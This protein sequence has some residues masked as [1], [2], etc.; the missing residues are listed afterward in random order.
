VTLSD[1]WEAVKAQTIQDVS[2]TRRAIRDAFHHLVISEKFLNQLGPAINSAKS[3]FLF[4]PPGNGKTTLAETASKLLGGAVYIPYALEYDG[5]IIKVYDSIFHAAVDND[6]QRVDTLDRRWV[7]SR[8]PVVIV[9]GE[10]TLESLDLVYSEGS[11]H[12]EAPFQ[13][14]ANCGMFLID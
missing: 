4:G 5:Q 12:Y 13:L 7:H 9:G 11:K 1:Y 3:I 14:K 6:D 8:R 2:V 10:L